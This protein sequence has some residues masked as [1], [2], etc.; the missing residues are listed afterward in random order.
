MQFFIFF[1]EN[2]LGKLLGFVRMHENK[3]FFFLFFRNENFFLFFLSFL[4]LKTFQ[5]KLGILNTESISYSVNIQLDI[6]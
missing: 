4:F 5:R 1:N 6:M 3:I 2:M